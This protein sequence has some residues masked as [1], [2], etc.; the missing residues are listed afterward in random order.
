MIRTI[1]LTLL[2]IALPFLI[3]AAYLY[4]LKI[5]Y[6]RKLKKGMKDVTP[7]EHHY[8]IKTLITI[9]LL[10]AIACIATNRFFFTETDK[11]YVGNITKS[12]TV[13]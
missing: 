9:G 11:P 7:P 5:I 2:N 8:P 4:A 1:L 6:K 10:M 3:R 13:K 12:E